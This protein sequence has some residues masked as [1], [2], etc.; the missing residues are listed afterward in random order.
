MEAVQVTPSAPMPDDVGTAPGWTLA[1]AKQRLREQ[2][3][4]VERDIDAKVGQIALRLRGE[5]KKAGLWAALGALG[6]GLSFGARGGGGRRRR[7]RTADREGS[8]GTERGGLM[9]VLL[10]AGRYALPVVLGMLRRGT[11]RR[12]RSERDPKAE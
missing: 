5:I 7:G 10:T 11:G 8:S 12:G 6:L 1:Q 4:V 3:E 9:S 2:G